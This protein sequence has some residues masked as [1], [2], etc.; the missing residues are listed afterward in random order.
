MSVVNMCRTLIVV[1]FCL[2][3]EKGINFHSCCGTGIM[4][5]LIEDEGSV[6]ITQLSSFY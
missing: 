3:I 4:E 6:L 1:F 5:F 2:I